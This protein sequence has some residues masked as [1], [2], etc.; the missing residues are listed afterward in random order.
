MG[1]AV[2]VLII[3]LSRRGII[4]VPALCILQALLVAK[5]LAWARPTADRLSAAPA[6]PLPQTSRKMTAAEE[7]AHDA[8]VKDMARVDVRVFC[9]ISSKR[10][11]KPVPGPQTTVF[12][13]CPS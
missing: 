9:R 12:Y 8:H 13:P 5:G 6:A 11:W 2:Q 10:L 4:Y 1:A 7:A 3:R